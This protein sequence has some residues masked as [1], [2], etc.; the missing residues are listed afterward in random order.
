MHNDIGFRNDIVVDGRDK[1]PRPANRHETLS[2]EI[3]NVG[4]RFVCVLG[5]TLDLTLVKLVDYDWFTSV[6]VYFNDLVIVN[7]RIYV[8]NSNIEMF[9]V[10]VG[11]S[12]PDFRCDDR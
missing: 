9:V 7:L 1:I 8:E 6:W 2:I 10:N 3:S 4:K 11:T 12:I 5:L